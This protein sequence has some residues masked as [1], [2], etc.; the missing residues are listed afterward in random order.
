MLIYVQR[1]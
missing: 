1:L